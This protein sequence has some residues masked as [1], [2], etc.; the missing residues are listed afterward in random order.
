M[1]WFILSNSV[2]VFWGN[3]LIIS[4]IYLNS[5]VIFALFAIAP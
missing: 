5:S 2:A 4:K 1:Y 3:I